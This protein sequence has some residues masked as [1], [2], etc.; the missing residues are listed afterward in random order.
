MAKKQADNKS[1]GNFFNDKVDAKIGSLVLSDSFVTVRGVELIF[2]KKLT[3]TQQ[4]K[5]KQDVLQMLNDNFFGSYE[6]GDIKY[7]GFESVLKLKVEQGGVAGPVPTAIQEAGSA[8]I[9][10]QVLK[11]NKK[12]ASAAD[13]MNDNDTKKGLEKIFKAPYDKSVNEWIHSYFEHQ[14]AFFKKFQP[15][16]WDVFEHGG[17]DLMEF[18][19]EQCQI[20]K[21]VTASG[22]L[23]DVGKY[24]TW[25]PA[26]IWAVKDKSQVKKQI[27]DA[28]QKD[29]TATLKEL[30]NVLLNLMKD[31]KLIGLSLKK[32]DPKEKANFV[33]VNKDPKKI[34]FA[35]VEEVKM[36][37]IT[38][39]IKTEETVDGMSQGG[40][41]LFG[42]YTINVIRTP[43]SG[44]SNLKYESVIKGSGGRGGAA[45]VDLV[46]TMLKS[47]IPG[48]TY[49][50][51]HQDY[52]ETADD[53]KN[54]KRNYERM[55]DSLRTNINGTKDYAE[56][57]SRI[58]KM[59][60]SDNSKSRAV[61]QSKLMQLH[62]FSD[63]LS[64]R[65]DAEFW[66]DLL[67]LSLKVGKRFAPHG[68]LA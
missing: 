5:L 2:E 28:I 60:R 31:N 35:Q 18:V 14:K 38:I 66:T 13:I 8:F 51:R 40:Y 56:F 61:A 45:P 24:E 57:R 68:K 7:D 16:Q 49:V 59:Y 15:A 52:P 27:D 19:K 6:I 30:N 25:N 41:V 47:K 48:H 53:F 39:E 65:K 63:V 67:Y 10:T 21:E 11:N 12:F 55:Y 58:L 34:E 1:V 54:D 9:L 42:K 46:A 29:G 62:F 33:Y 50:N 22:K 43:G 64:N 36:S 17:Q 23:K 26:D 44:F 37:D 3:A 4:K 32:I 20:V